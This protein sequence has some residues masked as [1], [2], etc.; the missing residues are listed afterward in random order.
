MARIV[1]G[2][3]DSAHAD[4]AL[5]WA[6]Q[7]AGVRAA[8]I[9]LV[10]AYPV[11]PPLARQ[12]REAA[13]RIM[14]R[15]VSRNRETLDTVKW[16]ATLAPLV[17]VP[18]SRALARA[19]DE[20]DLVVVGSRGLG[21]FSAL[22]LGST[23]Y[24]TVGHA[25]CPVAVIRGDDSATAAGRLRHIVV[26]VDG[27]R[28]ARR[29][30]RWA[31]DEAALRDV[32]LTVV[33]GYGGPSHGP[34]AGSRSDAL[35]D[36]PRAMAHDHAL[37]VID[38]ALRIVDPLPDVHI[39]RVVALGSPAAVLLDRASVNTLLVVGTRGH[40]AIGRALVGSVSHQCL[41][42]APGPVIVVP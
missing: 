21:G 42:H 1:V 38:R 3:D 25:P 36:D 12:S 10:H 8:M 30:L 6:V 33:H 16:T 15:L 41:H 37:D 2:V 40:G 17:G 22:L 4:V 26:G 18:Y 29:A 31:I 9:E 20:A 32:A 13:E 34:H 28:I 7:E 14:D 11:R 19:G 27:S 35:L 39:E 24:R 23:S 5:R